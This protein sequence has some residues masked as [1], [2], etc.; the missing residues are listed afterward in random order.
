MVRYTHPTGGSD[1][2]HYQGEITYV[3]LKS[4]TY[5]EIGLDDVQVRVHGSIWLI[6]LERHGQGGFGCC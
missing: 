5:W 2:A 6:D 3:P 1:P 4:A